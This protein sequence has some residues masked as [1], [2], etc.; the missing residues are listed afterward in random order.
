MAFERLMP[1]RLAMCFIGLLKSF[2]DCVVF[3]V[4]KNKEIVYAQEQRGSL[5]VFVEA[6]IAAGIEILRCFP[7]GKDL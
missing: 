2:V 6:P 7:D 1:N 4:R 5:F 3:C